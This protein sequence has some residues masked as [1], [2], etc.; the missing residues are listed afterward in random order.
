MNIVMTRK[1]GNKY[2][3]TNGKS[4]DERES[5]ATPQMADSI[6]IELTDDDTVER[7]DF[8][9]KLKVH[10]FILSEDSTRKVFTFYKPKFQPKAMDADAFLKSF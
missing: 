9:E 1:T 5:V 6:K 8:V 2:V 4:Y 10:G 7:S 3:A